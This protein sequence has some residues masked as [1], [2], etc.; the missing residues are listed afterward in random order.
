M[1]DSLPSNFEISDIP[2]V[3]YNLNPSIRSTLFK[4]KQFV[5]H[6]HID[7]FLKSSKSIKD[8]CNKYDN[9][10]TNNHYGHII[11]ESLNIV[12][13][14]RHCQLISKAPKYQGQKESCF[15]E[16]PEE[17]QTVNDQFIE[18]ILNDKDSNKNHFSEWKNRV[19]ST[20]SE[21]IVP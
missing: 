11:S 7:E 12:N 3:V 16:A 9:S 8:C 2:M 17:I 19:M 4:Y 15:E 14:E 10:F 18:R 6:L 5:L 13:N 1:R 20:E 21:K